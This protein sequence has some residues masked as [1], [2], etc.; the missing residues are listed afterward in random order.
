M[1]RTEALELAQKKAEDWG[2]EYRVLRCLEHGQE[3]DYIVE[4][5]GS[6][7]SPKGFQLVEVFHPR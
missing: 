2:T 4:R 1:N 6:Y 7:D 5:S 3:Q